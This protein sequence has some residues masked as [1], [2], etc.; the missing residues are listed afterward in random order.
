MQGRQVAELLYGLYDRV[1][2]EGRLGEAVSP[3][4]YPVAHPLKPMGSEQAEGAQPDQ[5]AVGR[6]TMVSH[7]SGLPEAFSVL[8]G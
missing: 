8:R 6:L 4:D 5:H 3:M 2:D 7:Y 1:I